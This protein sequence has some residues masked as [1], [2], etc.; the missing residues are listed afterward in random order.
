MTIY[1][2]PEHKRRKRTMTFFVGDCGS[3]S[4]IS[5]IVDGG[6]YWIPT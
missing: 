4:T 2:R 1:N 5:A 3:V 6:T